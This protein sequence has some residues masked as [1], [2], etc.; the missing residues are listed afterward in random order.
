MDYLD[1]KGINYLVYTSIREGDVDHLQDLYETL[2]IKAEEDFMCKDEPK[3]KEI[4]FCDECDDDDE[5][6][7]RKSKF[8]PLDYFII[9]D[10]LSNELKKP[11]LDASLKESQT[12]FK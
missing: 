7:R 1:Q 5:P 2:K 12:L 10:D 8:K 11:Y 6:K 4:S 3:K 9:F